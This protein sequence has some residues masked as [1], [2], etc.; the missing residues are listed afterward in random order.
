M[1]KKTQAKGAD[2]LPSS[3]SCIPSSSSMIL[4]ATLRLVKSLADKFATPP[5][6]GC[7]AEAFPWQERHAVCL[8]ATLPFVDKRGGET[9]EMLFSL[10]VGEIL[11]YFEV[12]KD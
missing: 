8:I 12:M 11:D 2:S 10:P 7:L 9:G 1:S 6:V 3:V 5:P 4:P